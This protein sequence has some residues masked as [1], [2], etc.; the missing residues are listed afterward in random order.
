MDSQKIESDLN[1]YLKGR[2]D[3]RNGHGDHD[4]MNDH[5]YWMGYS[6][7]IKDSFL[8]FRMDD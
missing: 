1:A 5:S 7:E 8:E 4:R 3:A 6:D 2:E